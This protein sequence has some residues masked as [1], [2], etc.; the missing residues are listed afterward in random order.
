MSI[1]PLV[2]VAIP[3]LNRLM[4]IESTLESILKQTYKNLEI[5]VSDNGSKVDVKNHIKALL[6]DERV[7]FRRNLETVTLPEHFN[8]CLDLASGKY[9]IVISD[10][11]IISNGFIEKMVDEFESD[12]KITIGLSNTKI[13]SKNSEITNTINDP[14]WETLGGELFLDRWLHLRQDIPVASFISLFCKTETLVKIG[15]Y[16]HFADGAHI[17]NAVAIDLCLLGKI[18]YLKTETFYYRVYSSSFGLSMKHK[19]LALASHQFANY[20]EN[21][22]K[23]KQ[24]P[25]NTINLKHLLGD[26]K[27]FSFIVYLGR[28]KNLRGKKLLSAIYSYKLNLFE[29]KIILSILLKKII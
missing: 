22:I 7:L 12:E 21:K 9:F 23:Q 25:Y 18:F 16:P 17:D 3:T 8:Q 4:F 28:I 2:T 1:Y 13:L 29:F 10:D 26:I 5:I 19:N 14:N 6:E 11:D 20:I 27:Y 15:K 24:V